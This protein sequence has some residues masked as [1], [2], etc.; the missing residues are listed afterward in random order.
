MPLF[1]KEEPGELEKFIVNWDSRFPFD[2]RWR[3]K[4]NIPFFSEEHL[5]QDFLNM[6]MDL[7]EDELFLGFE[8]QFKQ[9]LEREKGI[10]FK[11]NLSEEEVDD[12][13]DQID[14]EQLNELEIKRRQGSDG[15]DSYERI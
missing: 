10:L 4:Y 8:K 6:K 1:K 9:E 14:V 7:M 11:P 12:M 3:K 15:G 13:F 2:R 5:N